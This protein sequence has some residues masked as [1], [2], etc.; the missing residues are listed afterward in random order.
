MTGAVGIS[1]LG[2]AVPFFVGAW[3]YRDFIRKENIDL[4]TTH[5][6]TLR[7]FLSIEQHKHRQSFHMETKKLEL[8]HAR[9]Q[10]Y[11]FD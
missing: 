4:G 8:E 7:S 11:S 10:N 3:F 6:M 1:Y 5:R 9:R 2:C